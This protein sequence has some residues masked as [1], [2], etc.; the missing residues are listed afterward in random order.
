MRSTLMA[1]AMLAAPAAA[2]AACP[3]PYAAD[4][5]LTD[6]AAV[7]EALRAHDDSEASTRGDALETGLGCADEVLAPIVLGRVYRAIAAGKLSGGDEGRAR[8]WFATA[9][10]ID[11]SFEYGIAEVPEQHPV[12]DVYGDSLLAYTPA[13]TPVEGRVFASSAAT[14]LDGRKLAEPEAVESRPHLL[15]LDAE[16]AV[17]SWVIDG[18]RFPD[19]VLADPALASDD[20]GGRRRG[21][22][23]D[24][25]VGAGAR[26][27]RS[28]PRAVCPSGRLR[29][30]GTSCR[31]FGKTPLLAGGVVVG[32][33][34][35]ALY[36]TSFGASAAFDD[37]GQ[38]DEIQRLRSRTNNTVLASGAAL[39][40]GA[41]GLTFGLAI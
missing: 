6:M 20:S 30:D 13:P 28:V 7:E 4:Q 12:R 16:G 40:L 25:E 10:E 27:A 39:A 24:D 38:P 37:A 32:L 1:A 22:R 14:W 23:G 18:N 41:A 11:P 36:A 34:A 8:Q 19:E 3:A 31:P 2:T 9:V 21:N 5:L 15:Q 35:G 17:S 29:T 26:N 33:G